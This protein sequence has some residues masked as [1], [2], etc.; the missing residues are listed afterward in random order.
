MAHTLRAAFSR[1]NPLSCRFVAP[2]G[3]ES[4]PGGFSAGGG[5]RALVG[6][7]FR[8]EDKSRWQDPKW[9]FCNDFSRYK[10]FCNSFFR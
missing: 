8:K 10:P 4:P 3:V 5:E 6:E 1:P 7:G 2:C 9:T